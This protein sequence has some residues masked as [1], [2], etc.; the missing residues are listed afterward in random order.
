MSKRAELLAPYAITTTETVR[1][2]DMDALDHVNNTIYFRYMESARVNFFVGLGFPYKPGDLK[3]KAPEILMLAETRCRFKVSLTYPDV[4]HV[5]V[6]V[7]SISETEVVL[8]MEMYSEQ[9][10][11]IAA[12]GDCRLVYINYQQHKRAPIPAPIRDLLED[13]R[14]QA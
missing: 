14:V 6:G 12:E 8:Q 9:L 7:K 11:C 1:W 3:N 5:G 4:C 10:D 13:H 2:G